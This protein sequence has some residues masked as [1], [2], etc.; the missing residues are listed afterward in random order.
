MS[1]AGNKGP[2]TRDQIVASLVRE[3]PRAR[4]DAIEIYAS[5]FVDYQ[6]A[7]KNIGE[8]GTIVFHPKTGAPVENPYLAVRAK[9]EAVMLR[10]KLNCASVWE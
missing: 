1:A 9:V 6:E 8:H 3:N 10:C 7:A 4:R 5:A 2:K